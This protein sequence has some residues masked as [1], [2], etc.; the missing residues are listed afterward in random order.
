[1]SIGWTKPKTPH[2]SCFCS[3]LFVRLN[4]SSQVNHLMALKRIER[5]FSVSER[6]SQWPTFV[7]GLHR[8]ARMLLASQAVT[9]GEHLWSMWVLITKKQ[10]CI[11]LSRAST[12]GELSTISAMRCILTQLCH[13]II[14]SLTS[15]WGWNRKIS[16]AV[17]WHMCLA[18][19]SKKKNLIF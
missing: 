4:L 18:Q 6:T 1:M 5:S 12:A 17:W 10:P 19:W 15:N 13:S 8:C 3:L 11:G 14:S 2:L 16:Q 7:W 9:T